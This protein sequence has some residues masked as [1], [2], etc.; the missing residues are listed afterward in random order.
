[1]LAHVLCAL[2]VASATG[3]SADKVP[4]RL[5]VIAM[6]VDELGRARRA[7]PG[8]ARGLVAE[9]H[10]R[11]DAAGPKDRRSI[12][13]GIAAFVRDCDL[14]GPVERD[15]LLDMRRE[16]ACGAVNALARMEDEGLAELLA[17][18]GDERRAPDAAV[19]RSLVLALGRTQSAVALPRLVGLLDHAEPSV[20]GAAAEALGEFSKLEGERRKDV[21]YE[22]LQA[23]L[24]AW[25][26]IERHPFDAVGRRPYDATVA[27]IVTSL[28]RLSGHDERDPIL[29]QRFWNK[30]ERD[31]WDELRP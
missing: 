22:L 12:A 4:D 1:M 8:K 15:R 3:T 11:F 29:W 28:Q 23:L 2:V 27:A 25:E 9:L 14:S 17:A 5:P 30:H 13:G 10:S 18:L 16:V 24:H 31:D 6:L 19:E 20:R 21:F 26:E 7:P